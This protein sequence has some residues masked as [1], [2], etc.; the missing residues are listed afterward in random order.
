MISTKKT[1]N[2]REKKNQ[3]LIVE[4]WFKKKKYGVFDKDNKNFFMRIIK[5][6]FWWWIF[7]SKNNYL[8]NS[9]TRFSFMMQKFFFSK[10]K[11]VYADREH[12][13]ITQWNKIENCVKMCSARPPYHIVVWSICHYL[14]LIERARK[15]RNC[16]F[17]LNMWFIRTI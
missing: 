12:P 4:F 1:R 9:K 17:Q 2:W 7:F 3:V 15:I 6:G 11:N 14:E 8:I 10:T 5:P 13:L 16:F